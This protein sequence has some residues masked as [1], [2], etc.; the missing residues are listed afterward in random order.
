MRL[1]MIQPLAAAVLYHHRHCYRPHHL[2]EQQQSPH[3][4]LQSQQPDISITSV[5]KKLVTSGHY[6]KSYFAWV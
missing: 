4:L 2:M 1:S 3:P 5:E 6:A